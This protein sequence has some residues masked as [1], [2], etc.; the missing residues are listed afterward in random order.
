MKNVTECWDTLLSMGYLDED[1][2]QFEIGNAV[3]NLARD[4]ERIKN[5]ESK[6]RVIEM[7]NELFKV[8]DYV[9]T[10]SEEEWNEISDGMWQNTND[11]R[12]FSA[13]GGKT[14]YSCNDADRVVQ[15]STVI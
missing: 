15:A 13:D 6:K 4:L 5:P 1:G 9:P 3:M 2:E 11:P 12:L 14:Y 7:L 10:T 8:Q